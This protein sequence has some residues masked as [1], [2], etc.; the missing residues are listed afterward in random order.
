MAKPIFI[1]ELPE[2]DDYYPKID[3]IREVISSKLEDYYVLVFVNPLLE[4]VK[5]QVFY[6]KDFN[7]IKF[8]ELKQII[9]EK[10]KDHDSTTVD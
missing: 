5:F 6:E 1:I 10:L 3:G 9:I 8:E 7:E 4:E 2:L